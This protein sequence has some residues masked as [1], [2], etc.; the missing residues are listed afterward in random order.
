MNGPGKLKTRFKDN[1]F[2][3]KDASK[4]LKLSERATYYKTRELISKGELI[5]IARNTYKFS[6]QRTKP[7]LNPQLNNIRKNLLKTSFDFSFTGLSVLDKYIHHIPYQMIYTLYV[8]P[9][10]GEAIND[11]I[12]SK[13]THLMNPSYE[14]VILLLEKTRARNLLV[15]RELNYLYSTREGT[16]SYEKAFTDLYFEVT[17]KKIPF[18]H[19]DLYEILRSL[20]MNDELNYSTLLRCAGIR[21]I[22]DEIKDLLQEFSKET[23]IPKIK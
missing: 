19:T 21:K 15:A 10:S 18:I 5:R 4:C 3:I 12:K 9:G 8:E 2:S 6:D 7:R 23:R 16:A 1:L 22:K 20:I 13:T 17:R 11:L 14:D